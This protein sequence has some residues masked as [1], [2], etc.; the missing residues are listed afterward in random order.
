MSVGT[1]AGGT[2]VNIIARECAFDWDLRSLPDDDAAAL[3]ARIDLFIAADLLPRMRAVFP[4]AVGRNR[5]H[6]RGA[7]AGAGTRLAG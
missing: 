6:R 1:I 7:A 3:K 5:N 4:Q 2:A